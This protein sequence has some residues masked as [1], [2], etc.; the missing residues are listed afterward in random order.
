MRPGP[1]QRPIERPL[2]S[3]QVKPK[4]RRPSPG[5][6][7]GGYRETLRQPNSSRT[8]SS[9]DRNGVRCTSVT[10]RWPL[11][12]GESAAAGGRSCGAVAAG[13][14]NVVGSRSNRDRAGLAPA[15]V[16]AR[17]YN[18]VV[19]EE[20]VRS[21]T[22]GVRSNLHHYASASGQ[23]R[24]SRTRDFESTTSY[25]RTSSGLVICCQ[26]LTPS[27]RQSRSPV[28]HSSSLPGIYLHKRRLAMIAPCH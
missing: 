9:I 20:R 14:A 26:P 28:C 11:G 17:I 7:P 19:A 21:C 15:R 6:G 1:D 13:A 5:H 24:S 25:S 8:W 22:F 27:Y 16:V 3:R 18:F 12:Q 4:D 23:V 10:A 2:G